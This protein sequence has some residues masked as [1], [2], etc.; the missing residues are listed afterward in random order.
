[1][2]AHQAGRH[3]E[4]AELIARA[5]AI[6]PKAAVLH[7]NLGEALRCLGRPEEAL[8]CYRRAVALDPGFA[9]AH[10]NLGV[11]AGSRGEQEEA[12][13]HYR[14]AL[15]LRPGYAEALNNLGHALCARGEL[16][17]AVRCL[18]AAIERRPGFAEAHNNLGTALLA[19]GLLEEAKEQFGRALG[20]KPG[21][22]LACAN[23]GAVAQE[24][25]RL[26]EAVERYRRALEMPEA[27]PGIRVSLAAA[28]VEQGRTEEARAAYERALEVT[29]RDALHVLRA[30]VLSPI[31]QSRERMLYERSRYAA[32]LAELAGRKLSI[33]DPAREV[34][35]V[36]FYLAYQGLNDRELQHTLAQIY[37]RACPSLAY[38]APHCDSRAAR[39]PG[40]KPRLG[41][42]SRVIGRHSV[43][44]ALMSGLIGRLSRE[45][46]SVTV[47]SFPHP[48]NRDISQMA[49]RAERV[50]M[51]P[52]VL[53]AAR[54]RLAEE[55]LD[56]LCYVDLGMDP[57]TYFL[58]F[59]R[60]APVQCA[61]WQHPVTTGIPNVDYFLSS[62]LTEPAG[63]EEHYTERLVRLPSL[64]TWYGRPLT[65]A[66][67]E[68]RAE[69]GLKEGR[70]QY[71]CPQSAAKIHPDFD[72]LLGAILR[73]DPAGEVV[74]LEAHPAE[75]TR[76]LRARFAQTIP[77]VAARVRFVPR[78][79]SEEFQR[80]LAA[81]DVVL[82]PL[83]WSG[84]IT[85]FDALAFGTPVVTLPGALMRGR[86]TCGCYRQMGLLDCVAGSPEEYVA[87]AVRLGTDRAHRDKVRARI[88]ER[89]AAL[90]EKEAAVVEFEQFVRSAL[91]G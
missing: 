38:C 82:D 31:A 50:V 18:R 44:R 90:Y 14:R 40:D 58:A 7:N 77:D 72:A 64:P 41:F 4:A 91:A 81:A 69:L 80:F 28:L 46:F 36:P 67:P 30:C 84:G 61:T 85:T 49:A 12:I 2:L 21:F 89:N 22:A 63:A 59:A 71:V 83:H 66:L 86:V 55:R 51:L 29:P 57:L 13:F 53:E 8:A 11:A 35:S 27:P 37:L 42:V 60:L 24:E 32:G 25:G 65:P 43:A 20:A 16:Q 87:L 1:L 68:D 39:A 26:A 5:I 33:A 62:A 9:E 56:F 6:A 45:A 17:E 74:L 52:P 54:E 48:R 76:T 3:A 75:G 78:M 47:Y 79:P 70:I 88:L 73:A 23:L 10:Y 19:L 34:N 15:E